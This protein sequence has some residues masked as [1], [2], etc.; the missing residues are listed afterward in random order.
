MKLNDA[1]DK[2]SSVR[3]FRNKDV[4]WSDIIEA[5]DAASKSPLAGNLT[6]LKFIIIE[7]QELKNKIAEHCQQFW[8][9]DA[10]FLVIVCSDLSKLERTYFERG[11]IYSR[12]QAGAAIENFLLRIVDLGLSSCWIGAY[13]DELIK[14][15]LKIPG[16]INVEAILPIGYAKTKPKKKKKSSLDNLIYW[17]RWKT[18]KRPT[19][20]K[21]PSTS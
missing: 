15:L 17:N 11:R 16:H 9:T 21:E 10:P 12:Q 19:F 8:I 3:R 6:N 5:I 20:A 13:A 2:R 1:I 18:S 14:Q 7:D 4:R